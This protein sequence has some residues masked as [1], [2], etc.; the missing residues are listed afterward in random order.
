MF[1]FVRAM[2]LAAVAMVVLAAPV[3]AHQGNPNYRSVIVRVTPAVP[4]VKLQVLGYDSQFQLTNRSG[5]TVTVL[6]YGGEPYAR[7]LGNGTVEQ[8][9]LSP[10]TYLNTSDFVTS[11]APSFTS[12]TAPPQWKY[13]DTT[14]TFVWHDHRMHW[15]GANLPPQVKNQHKKTKIFNYQIPLRVG[16]QRGQISGTLY[17]VGSPGGFPLAAIVSLIGVALLAVFGTV[18][19]RRRRQGGGARPAPEHPAEEAW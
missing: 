16:S 6:G 10:A 11:A 19:I 9:R 15:M 13:V 1:R 5:E 8:N 18:A 12:T 4:G 17:W 14:S 7:I 2:V 3:S